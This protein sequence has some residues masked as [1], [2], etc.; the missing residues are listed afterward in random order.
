QLTTWGVSVE[1]VSRALDSLHAIP[2]R[3]HE[4][5]EFYY[6]MPTV[7]CPKEMSALDWALAFFQMAL[8]NG[9]MEGEALIAYA[10]D[11]DIG[12]TFLDAVRCRAIIQ[13]KR[14]GVTYWRLPD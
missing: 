14:D 11:Y 10:Y 1:Q 4:R 5:D 7:R 13:E 6:C 9:E 2:Y 12:L 8:G 3:D